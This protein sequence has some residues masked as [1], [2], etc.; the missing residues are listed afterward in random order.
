[1]FRPGWP[2]TALFLLFPLWWVLGLTSFAFV[3]FAVPLAVELLRRRGLRVPRGFGTWLLFL[4]WMLAG[5][6]M[7]WSDAPTGEPGGG[8]AGRLMVFGFRAAM[9]LAATVFLLYV[10]N[11]DERRLP[12]RRVLRLLGFMFVVTTCGGLL[13]VVAPGFEFRSVLELVLPHAVAANSFINPMIHPAAAETQN[14]L[15][16]AE[17][18]PIAPFAFAN[19]WGANYSLYLP[20]FLLAWF[21][22]DAGWRRRLAPIVLLL[23]LVPVV[24]SLNRGL[25]GALGVGILYLALRLAAMGRVWAL[26]AVVAALLLG[27]IAFV[28]S[29]LGTMVQARLNAPHSNERRSQLATDT[30]RNVVEGSPALGFG[31]T[32][33]VRGSYFSIAGGSTPD[34]P[35]CGVPPL[36]TQGQLW[37]VVFSQGLVGLALF[38]YFFARRFIAHC[39]DRAALCIAG[40][41]TLIFWAIELFVYDTLDAPLIT[42]MIAVGLMARMPRT[43]RRAE[44]AR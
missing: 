36:G 9:Y 39:R 5:A 34:C 18:R 11:A 19:S 12:T 42:V 29:P 23:S 8:G 6:T 3:I 24:Y 40:C 1:M 31:S 28:A 13:G 14:I 37:M 17:G 41:V 4:A 21:G 30:V 44:G 43:E 25:W 22:P 27:A 20:F 16:Y 38:L 7:L 33:K 2:L 10:V 35:A 15:G 32:R 26:Q